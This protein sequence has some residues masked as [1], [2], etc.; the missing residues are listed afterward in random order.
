MIVYA[1]CVSF[2][3]LIHLVATGA[4]V[5]LGVPTATKRGSGGIALHGCLFPRR[6]VIL[7]GVPML[8][9]MVMRVLFFVVVMR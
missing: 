2:L 8:V 5:R 4:H 6:G 1:I 3:T 7:L 9:A